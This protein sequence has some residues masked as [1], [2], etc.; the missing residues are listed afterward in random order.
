[1]EDA[2][3]SIDHL[4]SVISHLES[5][6]VK[7]D[8]KAYDSAVSDF[9]SGDY[10]IA[11]STA[12]SAI[13]DAEGS[14]SGMEKV[15]ILRD[16][17]EST[18]ASYKK[19]HGLSLPD[20][21]IKEINK[22]IASNEFKKATNKINNLLDQTGSLLESKEKVEE[23]L[24]EYKRRF[25]ESKKH[26]IIDESKFSF[27][28]ISQLIKSHDFEKAL[29]NLKT[30]SASLTK[31]MNQSPTL[32]FDFPQ[33]LVAKEWN[34][35]TL[36]IRN[37]GAIHI[38]DVK[39]DFEGI[40]QRKSFNFNRI[41]S[42]EESNVVGALKPE[43]PGSLEVKAIISYSTLVSQT[44]GE[45]IPPLEI[46]EWIDVLRPGSAQQESRPEIKVSKPAPKAATGH[47]SEVPEWNR[48]TGLKGNEATL[49]EFFEKRWDCYSKWP[50]NKAEL[51]Y[52]HNN[53][54]KFQIESY[55][56]IPTD[57][58][59]V[60]NEW[61]LPDNLRGNVFLD[62]QRNSHVRQILASPID[63][64]FVI[65]GEPGVGKTTLLYEVFDSF[66]DKV[67]SGILTTS[68]IGNAH[69]GFGMRLFYDDI[70]ENQELVDAIAV[71]GVKGI[72]VSAREADWVA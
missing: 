20:F 68:S 23:R 19:N 71:N 38:D 62:K 18:L 61:A 8:K 33:G 67:P 52:L 1:M 51:D 45:E 34:K 37:T 66:M 40:D 44:L 43:D 50:N 3:K 28:E 16:E 53:Q 24:E 63:T 48:P 65:I 39:L 69:I 4:E 70:P 58:S 11:Q 35:V 72:V 54:S 6:K 59:T 64:N 21:D 9:E 55:F 26:M 36:G 29:K 14:F 31:T 49:L 27:D 13:K 10:L 22:L 30:I 7:Y 57:P 25:K 2:K 32:E 56:E 5:S 17:L 60:L 42:G 46:E 15:T 47:R 41:E 12:D